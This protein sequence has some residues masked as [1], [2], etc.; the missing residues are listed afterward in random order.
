LRV[1]DESDSAASS[2]R[3]FSVIVCFGF[4]LW[5]G[6]LMV[7]WL[8]SS[9]PFGAIYPGVLAAFFLYSGISALKFKPPAP[10]P[11]WIMGGIAL[12]AA[13]G[14]AVMWVVANNTK[15]H[16]YH[17]QAIGF[18]IWGGFIVLLGVAVAVAWIH[19]RSRA[20]LMAARRGDPDAIDGRPTPFSEQGDARS[21]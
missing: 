10:R 17:R 6:Y 18:S 15:D 11:D 19:P 2:F 21:G 9:R 20:R 14:I 5:N 1:G 13:A 7:A 3:K 16:E 12:A 8:L 4:G